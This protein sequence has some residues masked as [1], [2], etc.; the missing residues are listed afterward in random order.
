MYLPVSKNCRMAT[1]R[2][3]P[4]PLKIHSVII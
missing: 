1:D 3:T 4:E 2:Q